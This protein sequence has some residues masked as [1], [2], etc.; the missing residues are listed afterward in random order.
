MESNPAK[1]RRVVPGSQSAEKQLTHAVSLHEQGHFA[2]AEAL[3]ARLATEFPAD[4]RMWNIRGVN[5]SSMK[6]FKDAWRCFRQALEFAPPVASLWSNLG[7]ALT[8]LKH[9]ESAIACQRRAI[10]LDPADPIMHHNL[11]WALTRGNRHVEAVAAYER[12]IALD[13]SNQKFRWDLG[14]GYLHLGDY[15]RGWIEHE[16]RVHTA[17]PPR[18]LPGR[19]WTGQRYD[20]QRLLIVSEQG[21]GDAIWIARYLRQVKAQGGELIME[22]RSELMPLIAEMNVVDR[23][24][25]KADPLP[26]ADYHIYQCS[27]P[28]IFTPDAGAIPRAPYLQS[29]FHRRAK[30]ADAMN[31][32]RSKL[33]VGIVWSGNVEFQGNNDRAA[34]LAMFLQ[35]FM[36]PGVQLYSLQKGPPASELA[37]LPE[38]AGVIDLAP[39]LD[40]FA[41]TAAA[42]AELDLIVMT[43]SGV[44]HLAGA[45]G[46]PVW[47]LLGFVSHWLWLTDRID[48][49]WYPSARLFRQQGWGDWTGVFDRA[50]AEL[51]VW[52]DGVRR[53][54]S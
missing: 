48:T 42:V 3:L 8:D 25:E 23:L 39:L 19:R 16:A 53:Q 30:F 4:A 10:E 49:P 27:L 6:R 29:A 45:M 13:P 44:L 2:D 32:G 47:G 50:A 9:I 37:G 38:R 26:D 28:G 20:G 34:P 18:N 35:W 46:K 31:R 11:G 14:R 5:F 21:F 43:D 40:D 51:I 33:R 41:D 17:L 54:R 24:V 15:R 1:P 52:S 7:N 36:L 22:C 12:A